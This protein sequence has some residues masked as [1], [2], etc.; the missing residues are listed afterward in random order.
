MH[1]L[2]GDYSLGH[3]KNPWEENKGWVR[4]EKRIVKMKQ[5]AQII[6]QRLWETVKQSIS[7]YFT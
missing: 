3:T 2:Q 1:I 4:E 6:R 7:L 5:L